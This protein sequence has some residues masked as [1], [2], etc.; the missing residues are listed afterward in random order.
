MNIRKATSVDVDELVKIRIAYLKE[1]YGT[2][3]SEQADI[4]KKKLPEYYNNHI[5]RDM[6]AYIAEENNK[7]ISSVFLL[8]IE[9]PSNPSFMS[10]KIGDILNVYTSP[11][12][13]KQGI[14]GQLMKLAI[15]EAK[16]M[17]LSFLELKA[18]K[19]GY[20]LYKKLGFIEEQSSYVPMKFRL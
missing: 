6:I 11:E 12:Y 13:R 9:K 20:G 5:Q 14:A 1:D 19:D 15:D 18:T 8:I 17:K 10:G 16:G 7:I 4:L 2:L 3:S